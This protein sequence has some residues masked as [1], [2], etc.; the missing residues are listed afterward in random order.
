MSRLNGTILAL[1]LAFYLPT[2]MAGD[3]AIE[4]NAACVP[5]GCFAGDDPGFPVE[6]ASSG[7]YVLTSNLA[8]SDAVTTAIVIDSNNVTLDLNGF[9]VGGPV[10]CSGTP[11]TCSTSG[12]GIGIDGY[13]YSRIHVFNGNVVG[14]GD[15]GVVVG[16][17]ARLENLRVASNGIDGIDVGAGATITGC[18][19]IRNGAVGIN[20]Y[21]LEAMLELNHSLIRGNGGYGA[22][23]QSGVVTHNR[24]SHNGDNGLRSYTSSS[25]AAYAQNIFRGNGDG[26]AGDQLQGGLTTGCNVVADSAVCP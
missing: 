20:A 2:V 16:T 25:A 13:P 4:I 7:S 11:A 26:S 18:K 1:G 15:T 23:V 6:I 3:G 24:F 17:A 19:V 9:T 12:T 14:F 8:V 5:D 10:E 21:G 22:R